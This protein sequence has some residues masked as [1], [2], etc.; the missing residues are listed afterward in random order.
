MSLIATTTGP[1]LYWITSRAAGMFAD[2]L[3]EQLAGHAM[4]AVDCAGD[5]AIGGEAHRP[6]SVDVQGPFDG[7]ILHTFALERGAVATSGI[8][9][10]SWRDRDGRPAHHLI[11]PRSG[12]PAF[13]GIVQATALADT[14]AQRRDAR[15]GRAPLGSPRR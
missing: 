4:F 10:R 13:T 15:Q 8:G 14:G 3:A 12:R 11:D 6:R 5:I 2:V 7:G 1:H 9:R